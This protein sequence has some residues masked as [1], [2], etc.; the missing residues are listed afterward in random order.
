MESLRP[1]ESLH[2][3]L[4]SGAR[5][6]VASH[7]A[8]RHI[9]HF[10]EHDAQLSL[11]VPA[12]LL[13]L[14]HHNETHALPLHEYSP[15][16]APAAAQAAADAAAT[17][18]AA[19]DTEVRA[20]VTEAAP[21]T[22]PDAA[23]PPAPPTPIVV[24]NQGPVLRTRFSLNHR[25][26]ALQRSDAE[27]EL[28]DLLLD[29]RF[30][31][32]LTGGGSSARWRILDYFWT[33]TPT[34]DLA[35]V[36][37]AG[38][39]LFLVLPERRALK[40]VRSIVQHVSWCVYSHETRLLLLATGQRDNHVHGVQVQ[41]QAIV[42]I[43]RFEVQLAPMSSA[44]PPPAGQQL[45]RRSLQ[46]SQLS[47]A[48][49]YSCIYAVHLEPELRRIFLYQLFK[50]Y[51]VRK[52][53]LELYSADAAVSAVDNLLLV[54][55]RDARVVLIYDL[56]LNAH[57]PIS[58]P[59]PLATLPTD[60]FGPSYSPHWALAPPHYLVDPPAGRVGQFVVNLDAIARSSI[61][62][63]CLL[64]FLLAREGAAHVIL[65]VLRRAVA[66]V[67]PLHTLSRMF[68]MVCSAQQGAAG[69]SGQY[70][71]DDGGGG[72]DGAVAAA[73]A[74]SGA[75]SP[76]RAAEVAPRSP[77]PSS[78]SPARAAAAAAASARCASTLPTAQQVA[79]SVFAPAVES[80]P[81]PC[82]P[83]S[84]PFRHL[85]AAMSEALRAQL[86]HGLRADTTL[87][88]LLAGLLADGG[89][90]FQ[91]TQFVR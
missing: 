83:K 4:G 51:V 65:D 14:V 21:A 47:V 89:C 6:G 31:H 45:P 77:A 81:W 82:E 41:P 32:R 62:K 13:I 15:A 35:V 88:V 17:A 42:R 79:L 23:P 1:S 75:V 85:V 38:V 2:E 24:Y 20:I 91:L 44:A 78:P 52:H 69:T 60:G 84:A 73:S 33:S 59:L 8:V 71:G 36:T 63:V 80:L 12:R 48:R 7:A 3:P 49:L 74:S 58:A 53:E 34:A 76:S 30:R 54:H 66:D 25:F 70:D 39:E 90:F 28:V 55:L 5:D 56:R 37:T 57:A 50:D 19:D 61:D 86:R 16:H 67:E 29:E 40:L 27:L 9:L 11:D 72:G 18:K 10:E 26:V 46:P 43:P 22:A 64:Q 87:S 68:A